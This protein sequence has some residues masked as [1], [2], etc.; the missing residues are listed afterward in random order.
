MKRHNTIRAAAVAI[1]LAMSGCVV[2]I[3]SQQ[4]EDSPSELATN[5]FP[6]GGDYTALEVSGA[7]QVEVSDTVREAI[8]TTDEHLMN[9]V[10]LK[11][12]DGTLSI[13]LR[14]VH[15]QINHAPTV[16]LPRNAMLR[17][18]ELSGAATF[19][20][21]WALT[22]NEVEISLS[23]ASK[24]EADL[25]ATEVEIDLSGA[26]VCSSKVQADRMDADLSGASKLTLRGEVGRMEVRLSGASL[27]K[28]QALEAMTLTGTING[29][30]KA[31][32]TV[33]QLVQVKLSGASH[34]VYDGNPTTV[35]CQTTGA[36]T[37]TSR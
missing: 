31:E 12:D 17:E 9:D 11:I 35:R 24:M 8:V 36:S 5:H 6:I 34:L 22:G 25:S 29:A 7:F 23:G 1:A 26:S 15:T 33:R 2:N 10:Q 30:S 3:D 4:H 14:G 19:A 13:W 21:P 27:L 32:A 37:A 20:S 18:V 28:A 16:V